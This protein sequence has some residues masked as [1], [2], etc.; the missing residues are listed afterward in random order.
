MKSKKILNVMVTG[1]L[2]T[3][4]M[5]TYLLPN[6]KTYAITNSAEAIIK[7]LTDE[8]RQSLNRLT[9]EDGFIIDPSLTSSKDVQSKIIVELNT[10][11]IEDSAASVSSRDA[12]S[13]KEKIQDEQAYSRHGSTS[14]ESFYAD[15]FPIDYSRNSFW[16]II[17]FCNGVRIFHHSSLIRW[18]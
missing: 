3:S 16:V 15:F 4:F 12:K 1:V 17:S 5:T 11:P 14:V 7:G 10:A 9:P 18:S 13:K 2:A 8:Q 6:Q